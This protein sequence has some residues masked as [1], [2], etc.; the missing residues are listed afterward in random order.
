MILNQRDTISTQNK[1]A[2][3]GVSVK[4]IKNIAT[5]IGNSVSILYKEGMLF[6]SVFHLEDINYNAM[7]GDIPDVL[8]CGRISQS[9]FQDIL[10]H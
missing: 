1:Y 6:L 9:G 8:I 3:K 10:I 4:K 2:I 7:V 5:T